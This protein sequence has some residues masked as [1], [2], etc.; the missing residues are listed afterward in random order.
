[1]AVEVIVTGCSLQRPLTVFLFYV[2]MAV[3][4]MISI[5]SPKKLC[6]STVIFILWSLDKHNFDENTC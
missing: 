5:L 6:L 3:I 1:M 2:I 4:M